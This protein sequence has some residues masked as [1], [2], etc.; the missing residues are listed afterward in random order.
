MQPDTAELLAKEVIAKEYEKHYLVHLGFPAIPADDILGN[1]VQKHNL[2]DLSAEEIRGSVMA[3]FYKAI[4]FE[5][6]IESCK[7]QGAGHPF[8]ATVKAYLQGWLDR[9][10]KNGPETALDK[11]LSTGRSVSYFLSKLLFEDIFA[12]FASTA[13][14]FGNP[15]EAKRFFIDETG[16]VFPLGFDRLLAQLRKE[17]ACFWEKIYELLVKIS[18]HVTNSKIKS[19]AYRDIAR[20]EVAGDSYL[21]LKRNVV[22]RREGFNDEVHFRKHTYNICVN[23]THE[24]CRRNRLDAITDTLTDNLKLRADENQSDAADYVESWE[25]TDPGN[26]QALRMLVVAVMLDTR[27]PLRARLFDCKEE[28]VGVLIDTGLNGLSYDEVIDERFGGAELPAAERKRL[29]DNLRQEC[30]RLKKNLVKRLQTI[31]VENGKM[32]SYPG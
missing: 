28:I 3:A 17:D 8:A 1:V 12:V 15:S 10:G 21:I 20:D 31:L 29:N 30:S 23:K 4:G 14:R 27:H 26:E 9:R 11:N 32:H 18:Q 2:Y 6:Y 13:K 5:N 24:Y 16:R 7:S 25:D 22:T 19:S